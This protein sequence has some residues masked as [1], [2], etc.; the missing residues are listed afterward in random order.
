GH[1][2]EV[3]A[4]A[5]PGLQVKQSSRGA[6]FGDVDDD[7][8]VDIYVANNGAVG[9]L[10]INRTPRHDFHALSLRLVGTGKSKRDAI[11]ARVT[12]E[13]AGRRLVREVKAGSSYVSS[14]D[15]RLLIG[16]GPHTADAV[17]VRWPSGATQRFTGV[18]VDTPLVITQGEETWR[19]GR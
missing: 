12:V 3:S 15:K 17:T 19:L 10:L 2:T 14:N 8:D 18:P 16:L 11:G 9:T 4:R 1:F 7:G 5:G 6:A 13:S